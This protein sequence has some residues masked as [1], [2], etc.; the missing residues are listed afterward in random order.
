MTSNYVN[1]IMII[2]KVFELRKS[3]TKG[4]NV[5]YIRCQ[6]YATI[7]KCI[8]TTS[9]QRKLDITVALKNHFSLFRIDLSDDNVVVTKEDPKDVVFVFYKH[10]TSYNSYRNEFNVIF[11]QSKEIKKIKVDYSIEEFDITKLKKMMKDL[12]IFPGI[13]NFQ[14]VQLIVDLAKNYKNPYA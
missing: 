9:N 3:F 1:N 6:G 2:E 14:N 11:Q 8:I 4:W 13:E 5:E 7:A 12:D 10:S